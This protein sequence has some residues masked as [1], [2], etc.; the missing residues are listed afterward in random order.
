V[1]HASLTRPLMAKNARTAWRATRLRQARVDQLMR[2]ENS[3]GWPD[4][5][6]W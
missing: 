2:A 3:P 1:T 6:V 5:N 4:F